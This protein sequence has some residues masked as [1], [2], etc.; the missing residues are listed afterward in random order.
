[1]TAAP[2]ITSP[3]HAYAILAEVQRLAAVVPPTLVDDGFPAQARYVR[4]TAKRLAARCTRRAGKSY[5]IGLRLFEGILRR[6]GTSSL[7]LGLTR[8]SA[9][10]IM[11]RDVIKE[12]NRKHDLRCE[13]NEALLEARLPSGSSIRLAGA[14]ATKDEMEKYLGGKYVDVVIDEAGSFRQDLRKLVYENLEPCVADYDGT[15]TLIGTPTALTKGL[16]FDV[17]HNDPAKREQGWEVHHWNTYDNPYMEEQWKKRV[18]R[19]LEQNPKVVDTPFYR[20]MYLGEWVTDTQDL[21]YKY[22]AALN[23]ADEL[24]KGTYSYV[25]G[26]D[27]GFSDASA[28]VVAAYSLTDQNLYVVDAYKKSE[29]TITDVAERIRYLQR[30]YPLQ[31]IVVD[32]AAKQSVEEL[33]QRYGLPLVAAD[34]VGKAEFIEIMNAELL[35]GRVK[36]LQPQT[37]PLTDEWGGLIW[38]DKAA[39]RQEHPNC[40]NHLADAALYAWRHTY[41]YLSRPAESKRASSAEDKINDW[42]ERESERVSSGRP[43]AFWERD[44]DDFET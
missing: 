44:F 13:F 17:T 20:R 40:E 27:L 41:Q 15:V 42:E 36:L 19:M 24:P 28:F 26:V 43:R 25:L 35:Q 11:W 2:K 6:P 29:M 9:R 32:N 18:A 3:E 10:T 8:D 33:K 31:T 16:F 1:M 23:D 21:V 37:S 12:I 22:D 38:D 5:G 14:D 39:K 4:S 30:Q 34:K 7:Y